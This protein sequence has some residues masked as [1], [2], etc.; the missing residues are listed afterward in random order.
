MKASRAHLHDVGD[1]EDEGADIKVPQRPGQAQAPGPHPE[2]PPTL[3]IRPG[4]RPLP[5]TKDICYVTHRAVGAVMSACWMSAHEVHCEVSSR[6]KCPRTK[7]YELLQTTCMV[8]H[9]AGHACVERRGGL[10]GDID[11]R[12]EGARALQAV[13]LGAVRGDAVVHAQLQ[14]LRPRVEHRSGVPQVGDRQ[15]P[16]TLHSVSRDDNTIAGRATVAHE[17]Q[18]VAERRAPCVVLVGCCGTTN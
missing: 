13:A 11:G 14:D 17:Q 6:V 12:D 7:G 5:C 8:A 9:Q 16:P 18:A 1:G 15:Q 10:T 3:R 4:R 2:G